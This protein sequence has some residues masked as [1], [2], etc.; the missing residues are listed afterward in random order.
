MNNKKEWIDYLGEE[1]DLYPLQLANCDRLMNNNDCVYIFDEVGTGK[2]ISSGLMALDYLYNNPNEKVLIIMPNSLYKTQN[3]QR[4]GQFLKDWFEKLP[5]NRLGFRLN[6]NIFA[7]NNIYSNISKMSDKR[8][9]LII[10]DEA[11]EF[12]SDTT[13]RYAELTNLKSRKLVFL[14]ATPIKHSIQDLYKYVEIGE[15]ILD[16]KLSDFWIDDISEGNLEKEEVICSQFNVRQPV[17]RYFK[18]TVINL[19]NEE[20]VEKPLRRLLAHVWEFDGQENKNKILLEKINECYSE[21]TKDNK[22]IV[23]TRYVEIEAKPIGEYLEKGGYVSFDQYPN[24]EKTYKIITGRN[25]HE[26]NKFSGHNN[27][28]TVLILTFQIA[29]QGVNLPG[30]NHVI[31]YHIPATPGKLEQRFGRIDRMGKHDRSSNDI[32]ICFLLNKKTD[33]NVYNFASA[34]YVYI[35]HL[36]PHLPS[37]NTILS[38]SSLEQ[39]IKTIEKLDENYIKG[40]DGL[41][42]NAEILL[43]TYEYFHEE[44][45]SN[46]EC[47]NLLIEFIEDSFDNTDILE[48]FSGNINRKLIVGEVKSKI[49]GFN[50]LIKKSKSMNH[51]E[52][53]EIIKKIGQ[54]I[55]YRKDID[56]GLT[57]DNLVMIDPVLDCARFIEQDSEYIEYANICKS[58]NTLKY[59]NVTNNYVDIINRYF[60]NAFLENDFHKLFPFKGYKTL[61]DEILKG[62]DFKSLSQENKN[63]IADNHEVVMRDLPFFKMCNKYK[64]FLQKFAFTKQEL[65]RKDFNRNLCLTFD[66]FTQAL[67][68]E[69][70]FGLSKEFIE[71]NFKSK[72][73]ILKIDLDET[74]EVEASNWLKLTYQYTRREEMCYLKTE[75][76]YVGSY[77][78]KKNNEY[79]QFETR[80]K[81]YN[82]KELSKTDLD[83]L[84][85]VHCSII[86]IENEPTVYWSCDLTKALK[87]DRIVKIL[88]LF[89]IYY[90]YEIKNL[91]RDFDKVDYPDS[92]NRFKEND[93]WTQGILRDISENGDVKNIKWSRYLDLDER[94]S[95]Y[96]VFEHKD[97]P[98]IKGYKE[99]Y[100]KRYDSFKYRK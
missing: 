63:F 62:D 51:T 88:S 70:Y 65:V 18:D 17:T 38:E 39:Y 8:Y 13:Q 42:S 34:F 87:G 79:Y 84:Y 10:V 37:K 49:N 52:Y 24:A 57:V 89:Q 68:S 86:E 73:P 4:Y 100:K 32:S 48:I 2:T 56:K 28:P 41:L 77:L 7:C 50:E 54:N 93:Y 69:N 94:L 3:N 46:K 98:K 20:K 44:D 76:D 21:N 12:L 66:E 64:E 43:E 23:F 40:I 5:F 67:S 99:F 83:N 60:E 11:H 27:L 61:F 47:T 9:G 45:V 80:I 25:S 75:D 15:E 92:S 16:K 78:S 74:V 14:T 1:I 31:N 53:R 59:S 22:F 91:G 19:K 6:E 30:F 26:L 33:L 55:F 72:Y 58:Y 95:D 82:G 81:S 71:V 90:F 97:R 35:T 96:C 36:I 85:S 29:E